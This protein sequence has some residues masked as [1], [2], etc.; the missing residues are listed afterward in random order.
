MKTIEERAR[1]FV[2]R[3]AAGQDVPDYINELLINCYCAAVE[4]EHALL[5]KWHDA[6]EPPD[7]GRR[8]LLK[9]RD[10]LSGMESYTT[11]YYYEETWSGNKVF[12]WN[13]LIGWRDIH[14]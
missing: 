9:V 13:E 5:T 14:E 2:K 8:V 7:N 6:N 4:E 10:K 3:V 12:F 1:E 11:G